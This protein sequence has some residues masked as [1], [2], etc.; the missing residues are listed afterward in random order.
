[1]RLAD[2]IY[3]GPIR[4]HGPLEAAL[5]SG[6]S[7]PGVAL[8]RVLAAGALGSRPTGTATA[9]AKAI[10]ATIHRANASAA[11]NKA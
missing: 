3:S 1:M 2:S 5:E 6:G 10:I 8:A 9:T 4:L 11:K 7:P